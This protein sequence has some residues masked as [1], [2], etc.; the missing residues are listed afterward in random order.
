MIKR[1]PWVL[2]AWLLSLLGC[3][4][5]ISQTRFVADLSAFLPQL[6]TARQQMLADQ[7]RDGIIAR[8]IMVGIEGGDAAQRARLSEQLARTLRA[9]NA[10]LG[11]Q[12]GDADTQDKDRAFFFDNRYLLSPGVTPERF[13]TEGLH[14]AIAESLANL[15]GNGGMLLKSLFTR[16]PTGETLALLEQFDGGSQPASQNGAWASRDGQRAILLLQTRAAGSDLD[17]QSA[18]I[19]KIHAAFAQLPGRPPDA[20]LVMSGTS[21]FSVSTRA[22]IEREVSRLAGASLLLVVALLLAVYRSLRLLLLGLLPVLTGALVGIAT[23]SLGF[24]QVHGL[25]L[26]FG[27]TLIGEAVDYSIYLFIQR[28]GQDD[29][30]AFWRTLRLGVLTSVAGFAALLF[31][32]F[33]GLSQLGLYSISGLVSA[34]VVTRYVLPRLMPEQ[35]RLRDLSRLADHMGAALGRAARW[36]ALLPALL[37]AA[38]A[39]LVWQRDHIWNRQLSALSPSSV[40][41]QQLDASLR[42]DL[43][44]PDMRYMASLSAPDTQSALQQAERAG[45]VL[46]Q[47]V[48]EGRLGGFNSPAAVLPSLAL[49]R[50]RQAALPPPDQAA[51]RL[52]HALDGMP[53]NALRLQGFVQD[54]E[55]SRQRPLLQRPDLQGSSAA[56]LA[57]SLLV[58]REHDVLA[59][60]PLQPLPAS[61]GELDVDRIAAAL[62][63]A[64]VSGVTVIDLLAETTG[65]FD[66]YLREA[67]LMSGFGALAVLA[68]LLLSLRSL[69]RTARVA[70][71]LAGAVLCVAAGLLLAGQQL[72]IL[73]L[74][75]LLLVAAIGSNYALF[76]DTG[77]PGGEAAVSRQTL[78]S[79]V[80]ANL[81]TVGSFGILGLSH[82]HVLT[83]IGCTVAPGAALALLFSAM[84][85]RRT[86]KSHA[87]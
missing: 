25:T 7:L 1:L 6:P 78:V 70:L 35:L 86:G 55:A 63:A 27:T 39:V 40:A 3:V 29:P 11:V 87:T 76:F 84:L 52:R 26:G 13:S 72:T 49:Q 9:D 66:H 83:V 31:S 62:A 37:L 48:R 71:P 64:Q 38:I 14:Q 10:F 74:V 16:D 8:L 79:L 80:V 85:S 67:L 82:V 20:R 4:A 19:A 58:Q 69:G 46:R 68:L 75:G 28:A 41:E 24:G 23:V 45:E 42:A 53:V 33:P 51:E 81:A 12:N 15:A 59:L 18:A 22:T 47:L 65:I 30:G 43:G 32:G 2:L 34:A 50:R 77:A 21:V 60:L 61:N 5:V 17:A 54:L 36:R 56:M 57:D 44:A 73:H